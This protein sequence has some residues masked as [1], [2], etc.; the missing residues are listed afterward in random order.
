MR[1]DGV[2]IEGLTIPNPTIDGIKW[3][4]F[5]LL[6]IARLRIT[7]TSMLHT[8]SLCGMNCIRL[9]PSRVPIWLGSGVREIERLEVTTFWLYVDEKASS[10]CLPPSLCR[11]FLPSC[12]LHLPSRPFAPAVSPVRLL[13]SQPI[14]RLLSARRSRPRAALAAPTWATSQNGSSD[15]TRTR[16]QASRCRRLPRLRLRPRQRTRAWAWAQARAEKAARAARA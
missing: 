13:P 1:P 10:P 5:S 2:I 15:A 14:L 6:D 3:D 4:C 11:P 12:A 7:T 9:G 8:A 16:R